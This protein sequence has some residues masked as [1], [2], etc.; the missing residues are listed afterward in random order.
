MEYREEMYRVIDRYFTEI[1]M[2]Y[3]KTNSEAM[4]T[5]K[6]FQPFR[7]KNYDSF[8][9][10]YEIHKKQAELLTMGSIIVPNHDEM[11]GKLTDAYDQSRKTFMRLCQR[12]IEFFTMQNK[13]VRREELSVKEFREVSSGLQLTMNSAK[14]DMDLLEQIYRAMREVGAEDGSTEKR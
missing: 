4:Q 9:A 10:R 5:V 7:K 12:N 2:N 1:I 8:I 6:K 14:R 3:G 13:K 11:A